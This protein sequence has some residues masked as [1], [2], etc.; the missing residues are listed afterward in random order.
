ML[1]RPNEQGQWQG[2]GD[3]S[4]PPPWHASSAGVPQY[5]SSYSSTQ[6]RL[7]RITFCFGKI[8]TGENFE[9]SSKFVES[10]RK[11]GTDD[12]FEARATV[13]RVLL[14]SKKEV[15]QCVAID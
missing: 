8:G 3:A 1:K 4:P 14:F 12:S 10:H 2:L 13:H 5:I 11:A 7:K 6:K 15:L 9:S